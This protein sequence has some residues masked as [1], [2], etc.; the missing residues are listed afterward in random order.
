MATT[1]API[2]EELLKMAFAEAEY[3]IR[4]SANNDLTQKITN[5]VGRVQYE[6]SLN[7]IIHSALS[8]VVSDCTAHLEFEKIDISVI[9][10]NFIV[11]AIE[12]K[13]MVANSHSRDKNRVSIDLHG[14]RTK[15]YPDRRNLNRRTGKHNCVQADIIEISEKV[16]PAMQSP[17]SR[18]LYLWSTNYTVMGAARLTSTPNASHGS[19][20]LGSRDSEK[21]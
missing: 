13:G 3:R 10:E 6:G 20:S 15:L 5:E 1:T 12:S 9:R 4:G 14:I 19:P 16:P 8:D 18:S 2:S 17:D 7:A 11:V 21:G